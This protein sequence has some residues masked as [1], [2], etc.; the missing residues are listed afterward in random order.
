LAYQRKNQIRYYEFISDLIES[1]SPD[2]LSHDLQ[3]S[4]TES[5]HI[6]SRLTVENQTVLDPMMGSGTTGIAALNLNRRFI[7][8]ELNEAAF[9][10]ATARINQCQ[11]R[12]RSDN[13]HVH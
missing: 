12:K 10:S 7:G 6:I 13:V 5:H 9:R 8:I 2:K 4:D 3:Q 1:N 11:I